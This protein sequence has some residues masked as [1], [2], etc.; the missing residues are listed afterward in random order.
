M[1]ERIISFSV[2]N[3]LVTGILLFIF[4]CWGS[5]S[6][7]QLS[8]DALPDVTNNQVL[9]TTSAPNLA[10]Q[11]VEQFITYP[12]E[13]EFKNL[14]D[15]VELRSISRSGLSVITIVFK[16]NV[17]LYIA[18][19]Q[20]A[21][22][23]KSAEEH[24]PSQY[25]LPEM[26]PPTTGLGEIYQYTLTLDSAFKTKYTAMDLRTFQDWI[27]RKQLLGVPGV[28]DV[29]SFGGFLKKYGISVQPEKLVAYKF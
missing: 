4:V 19:Q 23:I 12:L 8:I 15:L 2:K 11:E 13:L 16:D 24:I 25:G 28:V 21:E 18:R 7:S 29:S 10:T 27:V 6:V 20:V 5:Y 3:K 22:R 14:P 9:V 1:I 26:V 17:P